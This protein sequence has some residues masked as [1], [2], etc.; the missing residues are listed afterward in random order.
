MINE[1]ENE[2]KRTFLEKPTRD[3]TLI[4]YA[5]RMSLEEFKEHIINSLDPFVANMAS[6]GIDKQEKF[7]EQWMETYLAW[8]DIEQEP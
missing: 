7:I 8:M 6:L 5:E 1:P 2:P 3:I 4:C